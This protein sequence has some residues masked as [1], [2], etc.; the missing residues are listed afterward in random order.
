MHELP[1]AIDMTVKLQVWSASVQL[2]AHS[3]GAAVGWAVVAFTIYLFVG[4]DCILYSLGRD[5]AGQ[6]PYLQR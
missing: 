6:G 5:G 1:K 3:R 4:R 2:Y